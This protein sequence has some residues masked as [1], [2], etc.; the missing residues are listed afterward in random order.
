MDGDPVN[1][2]EEYYDKNY[3]EWSRLDTSKIE[4]DI[5]KRYMDKYI[6]K[7]NL[8]IIDIGGGPGRYSFFLAGNGHH[9]TL[10]DLSGRNIDIAREKAAELDLNLDAY[11]HS[12]VLS[13]DIGGTFDVV[14]LMGPLYHLVNEKDRKKAVEKALS[15]LKPKGIIFSTFISNY[16][17]IMDYVRTMHSNESPEK[18]LAY[19]KNG[20]F[21]EQHAFTFAHFSSH[22]EAKVLMNSFGLHELVFAGVENVLSIHEKELLILNESEY[23]S[24]IDIG[25]ALSTDENLM[26]TS[27]HYL[28]IGQKP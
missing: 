2:V 5:T 1:S 12:D 22:T 14:L 20:T 13:L 26:G 4:F 19:L 25:Y 9:V 21:T 8:H 24:W 23:K 3:D 28:Y 7:K 17:P 18:L 11:I 16:A 27:N 15:L 10:V 6:E